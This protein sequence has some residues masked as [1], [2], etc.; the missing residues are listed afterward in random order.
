MLD[1]QVVLAGI[2][3]VVGFSFAAVLFRSSTPLSSAS[4]A[5][6]PGV[7]SLHDG[8]SGVGSI[9]SHSGE[10]ATPVS[11]S[12]P[13]IPPSPQELDAAIRAN[14]RQRRID[15][16]LAAGFSRDRIDWLHTR[17]QELKMLRD[18]KALERKQKGLPYVSKAAYLHDPDLDLR[19]EIGDDEYERYRVALGR[20]VGITIDDVSR[21][22]DAARVGLQA[23]DV[24]VGYDGKRVFNSGELY[25]LVSETQVGQ[26]VLVDVRR[27]GQPMQ[28]A[29]DAALLGIVAAPPWSG[30]PDL[31]IYRSHT[32][33]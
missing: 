17:G 8:R 4:H 27:D 2:A 12:Q 6:G 7:P 10:P 13:H 9:D 21:G 18:Q 11:A 24:I 29:M 22:S 20:P 31:D 33:P 16:L 5:A 28:V 19:Y 23:D 1:R 26:V 3:A 30:L 14:S 25:Q 32:H 15:A